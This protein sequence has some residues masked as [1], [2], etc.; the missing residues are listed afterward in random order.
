MS[1]TLD[2]FENNGLTLCLRRAARE[3]DSRHSCIVMHE[4]RAWSQ[5]G[6]GPHGLAFLSVAAVS[7]RS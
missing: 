6:Q 7:F 5:V 2:A 4:A 3:R 1:L